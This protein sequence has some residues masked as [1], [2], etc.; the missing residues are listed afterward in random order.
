LSGT[1]CGNLAAR[2]EVHDMN[3]LHIQLV[4]DTLN[5]TLLEYNHT[6]YDKKE[7]M[8]F[9]EF[10]VEVLDDYTMYPDSIRED[11]L[12]DF[13]VNIPGYLHVSRYNYDIP[14]CD[15]P[16]G[17]FLLYLW[18]TYYKFL[19][20]HVWEGAHLFINKRL[21]TDND[22]KLVE[23]LKEQLVISKKESEISK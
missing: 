19:Q 17:V 20:L 1:Q 2:L 23:E 14:E 10:I 21:C 6:P 16:R 18:S 11:C 7:T 12:D 8:E 3:A 9:A 4:A 15:E 13:L 5:K 22:S